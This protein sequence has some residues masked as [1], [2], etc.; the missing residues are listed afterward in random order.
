MS[1]VGGTWWIWRLTKAA[2][3]WSWQSSDGDSQVANEQARYIDGDS[4][5]ANEQARYIDG[6]SQVAYEQARYI[7]SDS[8][9]VNEQARYIT[10]GNMGRTMTSIF[11]IYFS[12]II[13]HF[14]I[15]IFSMTQF[16]WEFQPRACRV[17]IFV[18]QPLNR[19]HQ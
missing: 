10:E 12:F 2:I 3:A 9:V 19:V 14:F 8:Q 13:L 16:V 5:V 7:D 6:D 4:Q 1:I 18:T 11:L 17:S 15:I